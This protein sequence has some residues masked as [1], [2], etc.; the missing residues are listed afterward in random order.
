MTIEEAQYIIKAC[1]DSIYRLTK[2]PLLNPI[3]KG[4]IN[5][6]S[7]VTKQTIADACMV[8]CLAS[9][10]ASESEEKNSHDNDNSKIA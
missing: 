4:W 5:Q 1:D 8:A 10:L 3:I 7:Q 9:E 6:T 2:S